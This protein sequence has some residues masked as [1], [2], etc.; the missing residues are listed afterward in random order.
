MHGKLGTYVE[1]VSSAMR[2]VDL[3]VMQLLCTTQ[4]A[5]I[6]VRLAAP[7]IG[8]LSPL[9]TS[10]AAARNRQRCALVACGD[11][12]AVKFL[13]DSSSP[14]AAR[15]VHGERRLCQPPELSDA[16]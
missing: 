9:V 5:H 3:T 4:L 10:S 16:A 2:Q 6:L 14:S 13:L 1:T 15:A 11:H 12:S 8:G 7:R